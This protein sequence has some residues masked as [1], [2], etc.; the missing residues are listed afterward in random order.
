MVMFSVLNLNLNL[1]KLEIK[2][3]VNEKHLLT[4]KC[5]VWSRSME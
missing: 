4:L 3:A 1:N 2:S 5:T